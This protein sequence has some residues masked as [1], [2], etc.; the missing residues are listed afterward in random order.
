MLI[1][2][3][4][5]GDRLI[6]HARRLGLVHDTLR[7]PW[8]DTIDAAKLDRA[9]RRNSELAWLWA[10][11]C[12]TSTGVLNDVALLQRACRRRRIRLCLDCISSIGITAIDLGAVYLASDSSGK[13]LRSY[14]GL[15]MVFCNHRVDPAPT[16][17]PRMLDLSY[18]AHAAGVPLTHSSN[19]MAPLLAALEQR[20]IS[21]E[22]DTTLARPADWLRNRLDEIGL[23]TIAP[24][25]HSSPSVVTI[26]PGVG[27]SSID[28]G[29]APERA[30]FLVS[31]RSGY[32]RA[33]NW[34]Q[35]SLM[36]AGVSRKQLVPLLRELRKL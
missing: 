18:Y 25:A 34:L 15:F 1:S 17:L 4:E 32:L 23:Q 19:P 16:R 5:F 35:I 2:N 12:E 28:W 7:L 30:G 27:Q 33:R 26:A 10:V 9:R 6:D 31:Y 14:P 13:G 24:R 22:T 3:G 29:E 8:G 11:I 20:R 36:S 21:P